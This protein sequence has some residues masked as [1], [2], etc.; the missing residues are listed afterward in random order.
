V[1]PEPHESARRA[2]VHPRERRYC[3]GMTSSWRAVMVGLTAAA[4]FACNGQT[5]S[6]VSDAGHI[7]DVQRSADV[8]SAPPPRRD[9]GAPRDAVADVRDA[10]LDVADCGC[11]AKPISWDGRVPAS[12]RPS[13]SACPASRAPGSPCLDGGVPWPNG[14][15][16]AQDSDC[17]MGANGRCFGYPVPIP[18]PGG[19]GQG[20]LYCGSLCSYDQCFDDT[21]CGSHIPCACRV[22]GIAVQPN[23]CLTESE[24]AV[25]SDCGNGG[26]CSPSVVVGSPAPAYAYFC[27]TPSDLCVDDADCDA[28]STCQFNLAQRRWVCVTTPTKK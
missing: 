23:V 16:C 10:G 7:G 13:A 8:E 1:P 20:N 18:P 14:Y 27:H 25:D 28:N 2:S 5:A 17:T 12:H 6:G 21:S 22:A 11:D 24:C 9:A 3:W 26:F 15:A 19:T 4:V